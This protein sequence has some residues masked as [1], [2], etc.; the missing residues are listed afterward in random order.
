MDLHVMKSKSTVP[1]LRVLEGAQSHRADPDP[2]QTNT[3]VDSFLLSPIPHY[4][5]VTSKKKQRT[6]ECYIHGVGLKI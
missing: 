2:P 1:I 5:H 4:S 3:T 6:V